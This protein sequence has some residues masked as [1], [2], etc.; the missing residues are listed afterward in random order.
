MPNGGTMLDKVFALQPPLALD[1]YERLVEEALMYARRISDCRIVLL[2][3]GAFNE[4]TSESYEVHSP[5]LWSAVNQMILGLATR[6][7]LSSINMQGVMSDD[8]YEVFI[9][10]NHRPSEQGHQ[11][12]AREVVRVLTREIAMSQQNQQMAVRHR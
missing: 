10:N 9:P 3:P 4:D 2:G 6:F 5:E 7:G 11:A 1:E 8:G 12:I